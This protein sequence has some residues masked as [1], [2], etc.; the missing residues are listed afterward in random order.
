MGFHK[1][2]NPYAAYNPRF[3]ESRFIALSLVLDDNHAYG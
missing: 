3:E 2:G 1:A